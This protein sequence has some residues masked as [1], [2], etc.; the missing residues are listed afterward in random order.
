MN[1]LE[2]INEGIK[3]L[4]RELDV[5]EDFFVSLKEVDDW[6]FIIKLHSLMESAI[7]YLLV[8]Y[9]NLKG[10]EEFLSRIEL[11]N[12]NTG[13]IALAKQLGLLS[14]PEI[15]YIR[16]LST[17]RNTL[18]HDVKNV[19]FEFQQ[20]LKGLDKNQKKNFFKNYSGI[21]FDVGFNGEMLKKKIRR[22]SES[23]PKIFIWIGAMMIFLNVYHNNK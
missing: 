13:K 20:Y 1:L 4:E 5:R 17:L 3:N 12:I 15:T 2:E 8:N 22:M 7:T 18:I 19:N 21:L 14:V 6:T 16:S 11:S 23:E 10:A 9:D